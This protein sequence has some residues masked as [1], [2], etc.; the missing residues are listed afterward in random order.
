[1]MM[2]MMSEITCKQERRLYEN[3][4]ERGE[5]GSYSICKK[6]NPII[7]NT[8]IKELQNIKGGGLPKL[9]KPPRSGAPACKCAFG[10]IT[11]NS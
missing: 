10:A 6:K 3:I 11:Y 9:P 5:G 7:T 2:M 8:Y 4:R 1:M